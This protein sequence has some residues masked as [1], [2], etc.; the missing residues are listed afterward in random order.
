VSDALDSPHFRSRRL[1]DWSISGETKLTALPVPLTDCFRD[2][3][4]QKSSPEL[5]EAGATLAQGWN[6]F[7]S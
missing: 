2:Q 6:M 3:A 5:D 1:F 4:R 7:V